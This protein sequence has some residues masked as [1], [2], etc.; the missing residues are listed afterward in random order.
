MAHVHALA[1]L[2]AP[3]RPQA[4]VLRGR[5]AMKLRSGSPSL[6][7]RGTELP[8]GDLRLIVENTILAV[9]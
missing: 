5:L 8:A 2:I 1:F 9:A 6:G 4:P 3:E 7:L